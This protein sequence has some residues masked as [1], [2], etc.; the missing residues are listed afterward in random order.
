MLG[1]ARPPGVAACSTND[2]FCELLESGPKP[3]VAAIE[4]VALGGGLETALACNARLCSPGAPLGAL[5]Y[6]RQ[7]L[8]TFALAG[9][10]QVCPRNVMQVV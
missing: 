2:Y 8:C 7:P 3:T 9:P 5:Q 4:G 6:C 10:C 1:F